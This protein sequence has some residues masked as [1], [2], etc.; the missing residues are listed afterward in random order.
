MPNNKLTRFAN[1]T[2][3]MKVGDPNL[4]YASRRIGFEDL[5]VGIKKKAGQRMIGGELISGVYIHNQ[6][7]WLFVGCMFIKSRSKRSEGGL[8]ISSCHL[9]DSH[10]GPSE[11]RVSAFYKSS[12]QVK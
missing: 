10:R 6:S 8:L 5:G 7:S 1:K 12:L 2:A 9:L 11:G 3:S 4:R